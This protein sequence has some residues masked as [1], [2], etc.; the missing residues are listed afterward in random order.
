MVLSE[1]NIIMS[2]Y[3]ALYTYVHIV[4]VYRVHMGKDALLQRLWKQHPLSP[5]D[6]MPLQKE[7]SVC[8]RDP[9]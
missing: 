2:Q 1:Y 9:R 8:A 6:A 4:P 5:Q 3:Y 7:V